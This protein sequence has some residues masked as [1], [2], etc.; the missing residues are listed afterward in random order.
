MICQNGGGY[1]LC[2]D[3]SRCGWVRPLSGI[4][5]SIDSFS[6]RLGSLDLEIILEYG[7]FLKE[8]GK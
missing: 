8:G 2:Q 6:R 4:W 5:G 3:L 1:T 7:K